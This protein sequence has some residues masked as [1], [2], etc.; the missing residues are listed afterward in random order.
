MY[1]FIQNSDGN[2]IEWFIIMTLSGISK[3]IRISSEDN[4]SVPKKLKNN[5]KTF[6]LYMSRIRILTGPSQI[7]YNTSIF[8]CTCTT[9]LLVIYI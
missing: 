1:I 9:I 3:T 6:L 2:I 7:I 8:L 5:F 4:I